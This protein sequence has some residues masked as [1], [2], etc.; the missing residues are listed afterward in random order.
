MKY[1]HLFLNSK[2]SASKN[3]TLYVTSPFTTFNKVM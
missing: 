2:Y 1:Q 3:I